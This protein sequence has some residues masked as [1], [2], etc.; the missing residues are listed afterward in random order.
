MNMKNILIRTLISAVIL[1]LTGLAAHLFYT[2]DLYS[3]SITDS[4]PWESV[5]EFITAVLIF[6]VIKFFVYD[7]IASAIPD[8]RTTKFA[9]VIFYVGYSSAL[10]IDMFMI[11]LS[12]K[13]TSL[14]LAFMGVIFYSPVILIIAI[15]VL[16]VALTISRFKS[17]KLIQ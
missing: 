17:S 14:N 11:F 10:L 4:Q 2:S 3:G 12:F 9:Q 13:P 8:E 6:A 7:L 15:I 1:L 16:S 5:L